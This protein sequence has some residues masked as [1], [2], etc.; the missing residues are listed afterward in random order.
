ME[1]ERYVHVISGFAVMERSRSD[2]GRSHVY[3]L[4]TDKIVCGASADG[5]EA[6]GRSVLQASCAR[7]QK[8]IAANLKTEPLR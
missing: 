8:W 7:C 6:T 1:S 3:D 4:E 5:A 2:R